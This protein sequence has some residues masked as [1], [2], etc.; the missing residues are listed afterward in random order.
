MSNKGWYTGHAPDGTSIDEYQPGALHVT[1]TAS[2]Q[3]K[4]IG[5]PIP[6]APAFTS[7]RID[8]TMV[9]IGGN[10][11]FGLQCQTTDTGV[12]DFWIDPDGSASIQAFATGDNSESSGRELAN[13]TVSRWDPTQP[14]VLTAACIEAQEGTNLTFQID[15][16]VVATAFDTIHTESFE[17]FLIFE[18]TQHAALDLNILH[19]MVAKLS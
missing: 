11:P 7:L 16:N 2:G 12:Y 6:G 5:V 10:G 4:N 1:V 17:P 3:A 14:H 15:G 13:G 9:R 8:A 18:S 19:V